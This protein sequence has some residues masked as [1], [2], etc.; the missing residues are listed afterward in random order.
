MR[1]Q[2]THVIIRRALGFAS[3]A[4]FHAMAFA[5][6]VWMPSLEPR[7][8][9]QRPTANAP[10]AV[11]VVSPP[12]PEGLPGLHPFDAAARAKRPRLSGHDRS[13]GSAQPL[14]DNSALVGSADPEPINDSARIGLSLALELYLDTRAI[15]SFE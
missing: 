3:S 6:V 8:H 13:I 10:V 5:I 1:E 7:P 15:R 11:F 4:T 14:T 12:E 2:S 9:S